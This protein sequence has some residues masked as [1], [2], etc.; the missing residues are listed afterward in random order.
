MGKGKV[1]KTDRVRRGVIRLESPW[2][3]KASP[4]ALA[5]E[6]SSHCMSASRRSRGYICQAPSR[7]SQDV[8]ACLQGLASQ[9]LCAARL[10]RSL[11]L[12]S[13][14]RNQVDPGAR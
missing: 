5:T 2:R 9:L 8:R 3:V 7:S 10:S 6:R 4:I 11:R 13:V 14:L 1:A 12:I